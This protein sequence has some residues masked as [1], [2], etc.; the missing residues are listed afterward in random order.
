MDHDFD[1]MLMLCQKGSQN[2]DASE[3]PKERA[4]DDSNSLENEAFLKG[5]RWSSGKHKVLRAG[6][7]A[8]EGG[9][10]Q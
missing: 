4:S 6:R 10:A 8:R 5:K 7:A 1:D 3:I 2:V 9:E